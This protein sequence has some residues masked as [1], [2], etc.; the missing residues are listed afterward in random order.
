M[1]I[2]LSMN[3]QYIYYNHIRAIILNAADF[4]SLMEEFVNF[5]A[6]L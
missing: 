4:F 3:K 5:Q 6:Q 2:N 1:T